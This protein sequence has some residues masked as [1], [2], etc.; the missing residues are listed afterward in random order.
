MIK[1][2]LGRKSGR[3]SWFFLAFNFLEPT[4]YMETIQAVYFCF[5]A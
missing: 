2:I 5:G 1:P 4:V 3:S